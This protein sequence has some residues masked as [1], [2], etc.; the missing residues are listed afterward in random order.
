MDKWDVD[1]VAERLR[2]SVD[3]ARRLPPVQ[4][5]GYF[6]LWPV[7][8]RDAWE[9]RGEP[10]IY[11]RPPPGPKAIEQMEETMRW[12]LWLDVEQRHLLW[13]RAKEYDWK[14]IC[15]RFGCERTTAWRRWQRAIGVI[16]SQLNQGVV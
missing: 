11:R 5:I 6:N 7:I 1:A 14:D 3:T 4:V 10:D 2:E 16:V 13:M 15:R 8:A 9:A 12:M